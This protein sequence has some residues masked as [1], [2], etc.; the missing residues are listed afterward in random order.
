MDAELES[1]AEALGRGIVEGSPD[2]NALL[3]DTAHRS[4]VPSLAPR[5]T[6][7]SRRFQGNSAAWPLAARDLSEVLR[8]VRR[9]DAVVYE[10]LRVIAEAFAED[11][12]ARTAPA[13]RRAPG[14]AT[15]AVSGGT[16]N[17]PVVQ[18]GSITG[19][20][21]AYYGQTP[22]SGLSRVADWPQVGRAS[23]IALG[24]RR[25]RR[26][27]DERPLPR[28]VV[29]DCADALD[30]QVRAAAREGGL[31]LV[32]GEPLSGKSRT[33]WAAL[34]TNLSATT[35]ILHPAPGTDLR[36]LTDMLRARGDAECVLWLDD[37][38]G[39]LGEHGLTA[40][41]LAE[42]AR[43]RVPVLA[44]MSD[45]AY[46]AHR[47]GSPAHTRLLS[48]VDPV[49]LGAEWSPAEVERLAAAAPDDLRLA[50]AY[51]HRA[52]HST[53]VYLSVGP[54]LLGEW[55]RARRPNAHPLGHRLVLAAIDL[56]RCGVEE[57]P[58]DVLRRASDLYGDVAPASSEEFDQAL[59]WAS[60]IRHGTTGM[61]VPGAEGGT[62]RAYGSLVEDA[63]DGLPGFGPVPCE[64]WTLA[65]EAMWREDDPEAM[66][67]VLERA[68]AALGAEE[69]DDLEAL[70][71]LGRIEE[72][73]G[74]VE[75]AE[76]WFRR[77]SDAGSTEAA[78][79]LG[80]LLVDR[81]DMAAAIPHLE[82]AAESG[83]VEA[84]RLLGIAMSL[85]SE[86]WLRTATEGGDAVAAWWLGDLARGDGDQ[87]AAMRWYQK[88]VERGRTRDVASR[89][90]SLYY[91]WQ[92]YEESE[93][94][95]RIALSEGDD[96]AVNDLGL[97]LEQLGHLEEAGLMFQ[98]SAEQG[99]ATG[100]SNFGLLLEERGKPVE[101]RMWF[102]KA[103]ELGDYSGAYLLGHSLTLE[104][105][106]DEAEGWLHKAQEIGHHKAEAA[107]ADLKAAKA[108]HRPD[109][110]APDA[111]DTVKE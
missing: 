26:I 27:A 107:L 77:A 96:Q 8:L 64:L 32:T 30:A 34:F 110:S 60:G 109:R 40:A 55:R 59:E 94:W 62:W 4:V 25:P 41:L 82:K 24:V 95:Y 90:A 69:D 103:H 37:L 15:N 92:E 42:L 28:Y 39:H 46:D 100:A 5:L 44:T 63:R 17:E 51:A 89:I 79:R 91:S 99:D 50:G 22:H 23:A 61:L 58:A 21:H 75:V 33:L 74:D 54:E 97:T 14:A 88:A 80:G 53:P 70:L 72:K 85:R 52:R 81:E 48:G 12:R 29:R 83:N 6:D 19:G 76:G 66:G 18:A 38:D 111:P 102:A 56:A 7:V 20:V 1:L 98:Q 84:Q 87:Q 78:G 68:R 35:R 11:E 45:E 71:T 9:R 86:Y 10:E 43:L 3:T 73:Y 49:E 93:R 2:L 16:F 65:V 108:D 47:F 104:Q 105:R 36:G 101:A 57:A 106:Y 13:P 31:V 67:A